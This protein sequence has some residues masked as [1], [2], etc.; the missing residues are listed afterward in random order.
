MLF[1]GVVPFKKYQVVEFVDTLEGLLLMGVAVLRI[2]VEFNTPDMGKPY[3]RILVN[4]LDDIQLGRL[5]FVL[6]NDETIIILA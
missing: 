3:V 2:K 6:I 4:F 5:V 1:C